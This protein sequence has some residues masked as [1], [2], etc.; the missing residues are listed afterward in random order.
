[1]AWNLNAA[2]PTEA[3][4]SLRGRYRRPVD[5]TIAGGCPV[6]AEVKDGVTRF[7]LRLEAGE[8]TVLQL[9]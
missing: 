7:R 6:P 1:V 9:E 8:G 5:L 2:E 3:T 4:C